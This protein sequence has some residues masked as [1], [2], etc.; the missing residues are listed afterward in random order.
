M[1]KISALL[2]IAS[3]LVTSFFIG[4][5]TEVVHAEETSNKRF[6]MYYGDW[7]LEDSQGNF[8]PD[9]M[10]AD[11]YTHL[12][13]AFIDFD[14]N[15]DLVLTDE[16]A[17][18]AAEAGIPNAT[19]GSA[20]SGLFTAFQR[21]KQNNPNL[22][23]GI[24]LGGWTKS[25]DFSLVCA[26]DTKRTNLVSQV[27]HFIEYTD[28]DFVD[29]DWEYP[30]N[31]RQ[32]DLIDNDGDEGTPNASPADRQNFIRLLQDLRTGLD[33]Q[34][35]NLDKTYEL[36]VALS[37]NP[38]VIAEGTDIPAVFGLVDFANIMTYD[39]NGAWNGYSAHHTNLYSN[40]NDPAS[41]DISI[42][43]SVQ[44]YLSEG[45]SADQIVIGA[46]YYTRGW[47]KITAGTEA[48][49]AQPGLF[50][51]AEAAEGTWERG[52]LN[53]VPLVAGDGGWR[54]GIW[55]YR[56]IDRL[57]AEYGVEEYWDDVAK[58]PYLYNPTTGSFFTY[59]NVQSVTE[60]AN[61]VN[62]NDLGGIIVWMASQDAPD[63]TGK[64]NELSTAIY[65]NLFGG[66]SL[67]TNTND[68]I[69]D[70]SSIDT[71]II[72]NDAGIDVTITNNTELTE[73]NEL[74]AELELRQ[75]TIRLPYINLHFEM[76]GAIHPIIVNYDDQNIAPGESLT[77]TLPYPDQEFEI[78]NV[79]IRERFSDYDLPFKGSAVEFTVMNNRTPSV[80]IDNGNSETQ[81]PITTDNVKTG[82]TLTSMPWAM[83]VM[84]SASLLTFYR[85]KQDN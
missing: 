1:R 59:D 23:I 14:E 73:T 13:Y 36:S 41:R 39:M 69:C 68:F 5:N 77:F 38:N 34:G 15:G 53:E 70:Y 72:Q 3:L 9:Q 54:A 26:D 56:N 29:V 22:K 85:K 2:C 66:T 63:E 62:Q 75:K 60:K 10:P 6:I 49:P 80:E 74:L 27:L 16:Q 48:D 32:P 67:P 43:D 65:T 7:S 28:M 40:P 17:A 37:A 33:N 8:T 30:G 24:S 45:A 44:Y 83:L 82:D 11:Y 55:S 46:A 42:N 79:I 18:L 12:N 81:K 84:L 4:S 57:K 50:G 25:G 35:S 64:R 71:K 58:A 61:Y 21:L 76:D 31:V 78:V 52:A 47:E 20:T 51:T 19:N